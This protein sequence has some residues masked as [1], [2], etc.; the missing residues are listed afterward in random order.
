MPFDEIGLDHDL[1][2]NAGS[3]MD[4]AEYLAEIALKGNYPSSVRIRI[5]SCNTPAALAMKK[6]L[7]LAFKEVYIMP[8]LYMVGNTHDNQEEYDGQA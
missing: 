1:G 3:G 5:H 6:K 8:F 7:D 2:V 4:V